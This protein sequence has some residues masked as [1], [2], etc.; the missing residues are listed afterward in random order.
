M[1][2][3]RVRGQQ[4]N[5]KFPRIE[6]I[7]CDQQADSESYHQLYRY[8]IQPLEKERNKEE[9]LENTLINV[10]DWIEERM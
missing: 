2:F 5:F 3:S 6:T 4:G 9:A 10:A 7:H 8:C 1:L